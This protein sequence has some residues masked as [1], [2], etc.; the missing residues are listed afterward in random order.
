MS[1]TVKELRQWLAVLDRDSSVGIDEGGLTLRVLGDEDV[2]FE[3]GGLSIDEVA[4]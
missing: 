2:Y 4:P 3:V 1:T